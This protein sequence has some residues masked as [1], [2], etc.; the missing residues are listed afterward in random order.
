ML[1]LNEPI[2]QLAMADTA[3]W[4]GH[5]LRIEDGNV[6]RRALHAEVEGQRGKAAEVVMAK[7][8]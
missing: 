8:G 6:L 1:G 4:Y 2:D 3:C 7:A 5:V